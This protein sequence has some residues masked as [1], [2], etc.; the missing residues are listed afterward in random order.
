VVSPRT[1]MGDVEYR[2]A[3]E[4]KCGGTGHRESEHPDST[5]EAGEPD[6]GDPVEGSGMPG[7]GLA[8]GKDGECIETRQG[9]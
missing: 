8:G 5:V 6:P 1:S 3:K 4:T 7:H 9:R 2:Q